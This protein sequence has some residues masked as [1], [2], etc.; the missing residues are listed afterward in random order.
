VR[1][2]VSEVCLRVE[3]GS[4][5]H[6][7]TQGALPARQVNLCSPLTLFTWPSFT[8][9]TPVRQRYQ[10]ILVA[11]GPLELPTSYQPSTPPDQTSP[12]H[13]TRHR[14]QGIKTIRV[15][16]GPWELPTSCQSPM[17]SRPPH[18]HHHPT[19][20]TRPDPT[21][22]RRPRVQQGLQHPSSSRAAGNCLLPVLSQNQHTEIQLRPTHDTALPPQPLFPTNKLAARPFNT[23]EAS[24]PTN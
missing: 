12:Q 2:L 7:I 24:A 11:A 16:A 21:P 19:D 23:A 17:D 4:T 22:R 13:P 15:A 9:N 20:T 14:E 10:A 5:N 18:H 8:A 1:R 6:H 3:T